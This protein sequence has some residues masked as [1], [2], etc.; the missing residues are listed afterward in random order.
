[1]DD[2]TKGGLVAGIGGDLLAK[3]QSGIANSRA[4]TIISG[5]KPYI[6]MLKDSNWVYGQR[7]EEVQDGSSWAINPLS[8][9]H[10]WCCWSNNPEGDNPNKML[11]EVM[12]PIHEPQPAMPA[13]VDGF[14]YTAQRSFDLRCLDGD[15]VGVECLYKNNS[16][17]GLNAVDKLLAALQVQL[18]KDPLFPCPVVQL[19][20]E[21][22]NHTKYGRIYTPVFDIVGWCNMNGAMAGQSELPLGEPRPQQPKPSKPAPEEPAPTARRRPVRR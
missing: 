4:I 20:S 6:R 17:G 7:D 18:E 8:L 16:R 22:Y 21:H 1:M 3:M 9:A 19:L 15:D 5:G 11:G 13:P 2:K 12:V 14:P 10:G